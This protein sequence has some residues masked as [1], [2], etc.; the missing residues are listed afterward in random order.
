MQGKGLV[1]DDLSRLG[2]QSDSV[3]ARRQRLCQGLECGLRLRRIGTLIW[4]CREEPLDPAG[5]RTSDQ[6]KIR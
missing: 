2:N 1:R 3:Y 4:I 6:S 5:Q